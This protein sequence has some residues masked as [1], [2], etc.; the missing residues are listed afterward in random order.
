VAPRHGAVDPSAGDK[1]RSYDQTAASRRL[2]RRL[3]E[4]A[5]IPLEPQER[6]DRVV[7]MI[8][9][10][11]VAEVCSVYAQRAGDLLELFATEGLSPGSVHRVRM[12]VGEGLVG[13]IAATG[14]VVNTA[15]AQSHPN[16]RYFPETGEEIYHSFLGVPLLRSGRVAGVLTVQNR[17]PRHY[18]EDEVEALEVIGT[19]LAEMFASGGLV[20]LKVYGY[21]AGLRR[22]SIRL[23]GTRLVEGVAIGRAWLHEPKII[24]NRLIAENT[25]AELN[26]LDVAVAK[27][28][29]SMDALVESP[30]L[31]SGEHRDVFEALRMFAH[32]PGWV[33]RIRETIETGLS[34]EAAVRRVQEETRLKLGHVAD[35]YLRERL[36]DL[37]DLANRLLRQLTGQVLHYDPS[38]L[39]AETILIARNLSA[40]DLIE[41]DRTRIKGIV[42]EEG[43]RT[44]HVTIVA[45]ALDIPMIGRLDGAMAAV[46]P[47]DLVAIDGDHGHVFLRPSEDVEQ[48]FANSILIRVERRRILEAQRNLPSVSLDGIRIGLSLNAAFLIDLAHLDES[49]AE[50]IGLFRTELT[51]MNRSR[52]PD[53]A[54][55]TDYYRS[56]MEKA[57]DLPI[58]FRTLD[59]GSDKQLPYW[60]TPTEENPAMGW[61]A[62]RMMLDR[63]I[64][65][66][67]QLRALLR[68]AN[69]RPLRVMFPM[70]A[71]VA[72]FDAAR[73]LLERELRRLDEEDLPRPEKLEV[74]VML[75]VPALFWQLP[76]ILRRVD[77]VSLGSND[78]FQFLFAC[79][80]GNPQL[81]DRYDVLSPGLLSFIHDLVQRCRA[82][83]VRLSVCGEM[84]SRPLEAMALIGLGVR[85]LSVTAADLAPVKAMLRSIEVGALHG[86]L[87]T[88]LEVSDHSV[89]GRLQ[90]YAL[91]HGVVLPP[92]VY[93]P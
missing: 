68:A 42:L 15:D 38:D 59:V 36:Q 76:A 20:D 87:T 50:G 81:S 67:E 35:P 21:I 31:G 80:R 89:R 84:A 27:F 11:M 91:D 49:G 65:M 8:A 40:A 90:A 47:G 6:L 60:R 13:S 12:R 30:D 7:R 83:G 29:A 45:R 61:R 24:I 79:D 63:P 70:V 3:I 34:A 88:L 25:T 71:E 72:E 28:R 41:Y 92:G 52:Y 32:D 51:F 75:E 46:D 9:T 10:D 43:S 18:S 2:L 74:G 57:G 26:R 4:V 78:L 64:V 22:E 82:S 33:R 86:Y 55:Q 39:P 48:A 66:R 69:G 58:L 37:D 19:V 14:K 5:A 53:L 85:Q 93:R 54:S 1:P 62:I 17:A 16:F 23:E 73:A 44:A 77:F 56:I